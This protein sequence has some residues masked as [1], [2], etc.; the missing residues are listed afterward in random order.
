[1]P[2]KK[3]IVVKSYVPHME[4][5]NEDVNEI[6]NEE[7][8]GGAGGKPKSAKP[9]LF[10][11]SEFFDYPTFEKAFENTKYSPYNIEFYYESVL[12]WSDKGNKKTDWIATVKGFM[13]RD[14]K[15][16]KPV[17]KNGKQVTGNANGRTGKI[18][19]AEA[20]QSLADEYEEFTRNH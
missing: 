8:K 20:K 12:S 5:E 9:I 18:L 4:N 14:F 2:I 1:L 7:Y 19:N 17:L 10:R 15:E 13:L 16:G 11:E 3:K 6:K